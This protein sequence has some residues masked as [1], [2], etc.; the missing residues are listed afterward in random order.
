VGRFALNKLDQ[1]QLKCI[2]I[3]C[4]LRCQIKCIVRLLA[5]CLHYTEWWSFH[6][7]LM[8][9]CIWSHILKECSFTRFVSCVGWFLEWATVTC[10]Q[11][12][13][14]YYYILLITLV[15]SQS[16]YSKNQFLVYDHSSLQNK[17][18]QKS[19]RRKKEHAI[20]WSFD[21][22]FRFFEIT[23]TSFHSLILIV[24]SK[25]QNWQFSDSWS[26]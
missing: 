26:M 4:T 22:S 2:Y 19:K 5:P 20:E 21:E 8:E 18:K 9:F 16:T 1:I 14:I 24:F 3:T 23:R 13:S 25:N 7:G 12:L 6:S 17:T 10:P 15:D 11:H